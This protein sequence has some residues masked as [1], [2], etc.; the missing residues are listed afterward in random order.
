MLH[1]I[2]KKEL[3][4]TCSYKIRVLAWMVL[5]NNIMIYAWTRILRFL[6]LIGRFP[7]HSASGNDLGI[8][9]LLFNTNVH[10][11]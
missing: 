7:E 11:K 1:Y 9:M 3:I 8:S 2:N 4:I 10:G 6:S 5:C